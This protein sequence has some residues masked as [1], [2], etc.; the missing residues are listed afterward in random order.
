M[1]R[2]SYARKNEPDL[3]D[4]NF[5]N[6]DVNRMPRTHTLGG[7]TSTNFGMTVTL[8]VE[9]KSNTFC[10]RLLRP[11]GPVPSNTGKSSQ[12]FHAPGFP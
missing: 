11:C 1:C 8:P 4:K 7:Q 9:N 12:A 10:E 2:P 6:D 5:L 3:P